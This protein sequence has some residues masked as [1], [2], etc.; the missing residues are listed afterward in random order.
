MKREA[1]YL[2]VVAVLALGVIALY[3]AGQTGFTGYAVS[4]DNDEN[5]FFGGNATYDNLIWSGS[6]VVL[7]DTN[8]SGTYIS[9]IIDAGND[10]VWNNLTWV[11]EGN[12]TFE[13]KSCEDSACANYSETTFT[14]DFADFSSLNLTG[15]YAQYEIT[16]TPEEN[17]TASLESVSIDYSLVEVEE[18]SLYV[19]I[20]EPS[21]SSYDEEEEI[22][23]KF[24]SN[25]Q[26]VTCS[27]VLL[28][29]DSGFGSVSL[30]N[31]LNHSSTFEIE[32]E[33][34][35]T[36]IVYVNETNASLGSAS[37]SVEFSVEEVDSDEDNENQESESESET[38]ATETSA[39]TPSYAAE[40]SSSDFEILSLQPGV[41][42]ELSWVV[43]NTG[44]SPA[45]SCSFTSLG[46]L[47][48]WVS[49][50]SGDSIYLGA[51]SQI[52]L[53]FSINLPQEVSFGEYI[54]TISL[55]CTF[56]DL[57]KDIAVNVLGPEV[58]EVT[59][60]DVSRGSFLSGFAV[61]EGVGTGSYIL[62]VL[63]VAGVVGVI[64]ISRKMRKEGKSLK[65]IFEVF[66]KFGRTDSE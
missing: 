34:D 35:Y 61:F 6:A 12:L 10:S 43:N 47:S 20:S 21:G 52:S 33:G 5:S 16:F 53:D 62:F 59:Q 25:G 46:D 24:N 44:D 65:D 7:N 31:C 51:L 54:L 19:E 50:V 57:S 13:F 2:V 4:I 45:G 26:N 38:T 60:E 14:G 37:D 64:F 66:S 3:Y 27:Y 48:S 56:G 40:L 28:K 63:V 42:Q 8:V 36:L 32:D 1:H 39:E 15:R 18:D 22:P 11:G 30:S 55:Q 9:N 58:A 41:S 49:Y 29:D 17:V 23:L